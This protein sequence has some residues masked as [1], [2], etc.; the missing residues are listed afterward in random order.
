MCKCLQVFIYWE[1][2]FVTLPPHLIFDVTDLDLS[3]EEGVFGWW[4]AK[5]ADVGGAI[6]ERGRWRSGG[7]RWWG[8]SEVY[9]FPWFHPLFIWDGWHPCP[10]FHGISPPFFVCFPVR[11]STPILCCLCLFF[12]SLPCFLGFFGVKHSLW[13]SHIA[14]AKREGGGKNGWSI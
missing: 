8:G 7:R 4:A 10:H 6:R 13:T 2:E 5:F 9:D 14:E 1:K 11:V 3:E 12:A